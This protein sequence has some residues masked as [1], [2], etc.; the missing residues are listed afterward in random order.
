MAKTLKV[1]LEKYEYEMGVEVSRR[2]QESSKKKGDKDVEDYNAKTR[3]ADKDA[4]E[5]GPS[6]VA[7]C[8]RFGIFFDGS[9]DTYGIPD[10]LW[11]KL[12][13]KRSRNAD[14]PN[15]PVRSRDVNKPD[16]AMVSITG[17]N[18]N[19]TIHGWQ[20]RSW[21]INNIAPSSP[22]PSRRPG[23]FCYKENFRPLS[24]LIRYIAD[25]L[26]ENLLEIKAELEEEEAAVANG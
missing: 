26:Q 18:G 22:D 23:R 14:N 7:V 10:A 25:A 15:L 17:E 6:E 19:Y 9:Y 2:R 13:V 21:I 3:A 11:G 16:C 1:K 20:M 8:K 4:L 12:E 24:E 5:S